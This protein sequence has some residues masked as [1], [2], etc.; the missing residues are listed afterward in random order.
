MTSAEVELLRKFMVGEFDEIK[1]RIAALSNLILGEDQQ[2]G[3]AGDLRNHLTEH[4]EREVITAARVA[5][6]RRCAH[7]LREYWLV[8]CGFAVLMFWIVDLMVNHVTFVFD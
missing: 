2:H 6:I 7:I 5:P 3:I 1:G 8:F 4:R